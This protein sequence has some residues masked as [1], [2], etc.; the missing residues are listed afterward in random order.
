MARPRS[1]KTVVASLFDGAAS[2]IYLLDE[3]RTIVYANESLANWLGR[4][5]DDVI[6]LR[7]DYHASVA[8]TDKDSQV[9]GLTPPQ[10]LTGESFTAEVAA[11]QPDGTLEIRL[12]TFQNLKAEGRLIGVL[13]VVASTDSERP[14]V[15]EPDAA[16]QLLLR[17]RSEYRERYRFDRFIGNSP[18]IVA[19]RERMQ[20][21]AESR[22]RLVAIGPP[23]S[24]CEH[25][26]RSIHE[27]RHAD[28]QSTLTPLACDLLDAGIFRNA[29]NAIANHSSDWVEAGGGL[30]LLDVDNLAEA[31]QSELAEFL[32]SKETDLEILATARK[33]LHELSRQ[34]TFREDLADRLSTLQVEL[35]PLIDRR[36]D[37]PLLV[38]FAIER[39][40]ARG[41]K[42]LYGA[43]PE[44]NDL[45]MA[46][47]WPRN[48]DELFE[49]V[50]IA[51]QRATGP[52][53]KES[54]LPNRIHLAADAAKFPIEKDVEIDLDEFLSEIEAELIDRAMARAKG[55]RAQAARLL[56]MNRARFLRR[57][58]HVQKRHSAASSDLDE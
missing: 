39:F 31:A 11:A 43:T 33:S 25:V 18:Q 23:G 45:L 55:N 15:E 56:S 36:T 22:G 49:Y 47:Y 6:G 13:G 3:K 27:L 29:L 21:A 51:C 19:A 16:H 24:G 50:E 30:L 42:Q 12:A 7:C 2:P 10:N 26:A 1:P 38:Q 34:G 40:N 20:V 35:P 54:D 9:A 4:S 14:V 28:D 8:L 53:I 32:A 44:A 52:R 46:Y 58:E 48:V 37:V 57:L 41:A 17:L 5:R